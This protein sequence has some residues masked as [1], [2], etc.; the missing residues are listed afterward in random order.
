MVDGQRGEEDDGAQRR[1]LLVEELCEVADVALLRGVGDAGLLVRADGGEVEERGVGGWVVELVEEEAGDDGAG[2][3]AAR[4]AVDDDD[5]ALV[6]GVE[7]VHLVD[8]ADEAEERGVVVVGE[9][10]VADAVVERAGRVLRLGQVEDEV[11]VGVALLG[12]SR[13]GRTLR[14]RATSAMLLR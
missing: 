6:G 7:A 11:V 8:D 4:E 9:R 1:R 12:V 5:V 10:E 2:A 13:G 14:S 3:A